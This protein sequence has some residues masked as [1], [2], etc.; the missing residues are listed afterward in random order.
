MLVVRP[1]N[2]GDLDHL[3]ELAILS[4][5]GF[6]SL[7]EDPDM[8]ADRLDV[9]R[10]SFLGRLEP[11]ERW[12]TLMLE[13]TDTGDV[14]GV[15]SVKAAVGLKRPFFSFRVVNNTQSS[16]SLG[17]KLDQKTL[18]LVNECT[19]WTEVG[20]LFLKAD[21][22]KGGAGRL[23]S[24]SRYMLIGAEPDLFADNVLAEL[25]G[26]FTP[27]GACPF[28]DHVAHK[29][30]PM[31]FDEAD[32]MTG[33]T[34]KQFILDLAPRHP[35]YIELLPEPARAVIG[36][37]HPQGV[38]AMALLESEGFRPNGLVD[39]FDAGPTV[40]C[41]RDNIRTVR[42]ARRLKVEIVDEPDVELV[43]LISTDSVNDF[44]AVRQRVEIEGE[45]ARLNR[46]TAAALKVKS[47]DVVRVKS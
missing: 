26:V 45:T 14:D 31:E 15:G 30:F 40:A 18:V 25:R 17:V 16:P 23:L 5:P 39:I 6:T 24:Q 9:S 43:S 12:Y 3:L 36:K 34:D 1:A 19:G 22:R 10:D 38:P 4:G 32:R 44:R 29:F 27:D 46:E 47:G 28:W 41:G 8:L 33:S 37:V 13:E 20:S 2:P 21:R 42:D 7:P 11:Q 35:I